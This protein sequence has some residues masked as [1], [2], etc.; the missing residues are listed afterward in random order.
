MSLYGQ[1]TPG[2]NLWLCSQDEE[3]KKS[4]FAPLWKKWKKGKIERRT[5]EVLFQLILDGQG[6]I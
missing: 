5:N 4:F 3:K 1:D 6:A 2:F